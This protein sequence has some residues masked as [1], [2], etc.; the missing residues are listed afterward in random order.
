MVT[1]ARKS[2]VKMTLRLFQPLS[3][4]MNIVPTLLRQFRRSLQIKKII[5]NASRMLQFAEQP[6]K[7]N[8]KPR[9]KVGYL[10][11][12]I[13][14][15]IKRSKVGA[16]TRGITGKRSNNWSMV[17]SIH[18]G[19]EITTWMEYKASKPKAQNHKQSNIFKIRTSFLK[20]SFFA[21]VLPA[22]WR[23]KPGF[24]FFLK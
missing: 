22:S 4:V 21:K 24:Y 9:K 10:L 13:P 1:F 6:K 12:R 16:I 18:N 20:R 11:T 7:I 15:A 8:Q 23:Y 17:G 14:L 3:V 5:T 2:S 19:S